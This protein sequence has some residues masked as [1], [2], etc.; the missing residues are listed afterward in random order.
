MKNDTY[1]M[2]IKIKTKEKPKNTIKLKTTVPT[3]IRGTYYD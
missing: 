1:D 2:K 3:R